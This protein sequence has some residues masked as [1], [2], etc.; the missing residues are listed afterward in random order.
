MPGRSAIEKGDKKVKGGPAANL[1]K[2]PG[3]CARLGVGMDA[4]D[5]KGEGNGKSAG[6]D[7]RQHVG[8]PGH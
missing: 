7:D 3:E 4:A 8:N 6:N 1:A 5:C 2:R